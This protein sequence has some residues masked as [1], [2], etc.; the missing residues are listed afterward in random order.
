MEKNSHECRVYESADD[1]SLSQAIAQYLT[2]KR[3]Q[4]VMG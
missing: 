2:E 3:L 1:K 4:A